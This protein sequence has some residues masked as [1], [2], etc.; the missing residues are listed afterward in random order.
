MDIRFSILVK[1]YRPNASP[2]RDY[3]DVQCGKWNRHYYI[4]IGI[5]L[6][7]SCKRDSNISN[8]VSTSLPTS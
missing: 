3:V 7:C 6:T 4:I 5:N 1:C 2:L 8:K